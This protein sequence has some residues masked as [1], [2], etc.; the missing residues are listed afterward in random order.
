VPPGESFIN[1][2]DTVSIFISNIAAGFTK[3]QFVLKV[4]KDSFFQI[5]PQFSD[6]SIEGFFK[7]F[8]KQINLSVPTQLSQNEAEV[9]FMVVQH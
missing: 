8:Y 2:S 7:S 3:W 1:L 6:N 4:G 5:T 9:A